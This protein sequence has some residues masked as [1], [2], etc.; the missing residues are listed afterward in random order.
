MDILIPD[1]L[2][3]VTLEQYVKYNSLPEDL[4]PVDKETEIIHIFTQISRANIR[5]MT[6]A[7]R[8]EV[9]RL[10]T[11]ALGEEDHALVLTTTLQ[12]ETLGFV[13]NLDQL[14]L[15]EFVDIESYQKDPQDWDKVM[16]VLYRPIIS[17]R[18]NAYEV[19]DYDAALKLDLDYSLLP[20]NVVF[21]ALVFFCDLG[22]DLISHILRSLKGAPTPL[23][24]S[25]TS[26]LN[27]VGME[28]Y[29]DLLRAISD[30]LIESKRQLCIK[31]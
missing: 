1:E 11:A 19:M 30:G 14:T 2:K 27:G 31:L 24:R 13:P 5:K 25:I 4:N 22:N 26:E 16:R 7:S 18:K 20:M 15:G 17:Q 12:G 9:L 8:S 3:D 6:M 28:Q 23:K 29:M 10:L 21:G